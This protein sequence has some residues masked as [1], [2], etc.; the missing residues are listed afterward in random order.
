MNKKLLLG[1]YYLNPTFSTQ[2]NDNIPGKNYLT[3]NKYIPSEPDFKRPIL[4]VMSAVRTEYCCSYD[5]INVAISVHNNN[6][7]QW[8]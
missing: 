3:T 7:T 4:A 8:G 2:S 5:W 1:L 6:L